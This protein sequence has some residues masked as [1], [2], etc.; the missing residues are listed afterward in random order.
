MGGRKNTET[1]FFTEKGPSG[2]DLPLDSP[3]KARS[4]ASGKSGDSQAE[5]EDEIGLTMH[6]FQPD[7]ELRGWKTKVAHAVQLGE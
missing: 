7:T 2:A 4:R 5:L 1:K 6:P 3:R